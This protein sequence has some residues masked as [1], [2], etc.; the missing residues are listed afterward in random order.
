MGTRHGHVLQ[1]VHE[2]KNPLLR[3]CRHRGGAEL[4]ERRP[5]SKGINE[6]E[7]A[8]KPHGDPNGGSNHPGGRPCWKRAHRDWRG[9]IEAICILA[10]MIIYIMT[11]DMRG[12]PNGRTQPASPNSV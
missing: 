5:I 2:S 1:A 8:H 6:M 7:I 12:R 11:G 9:W 4:V 10:A 3:S